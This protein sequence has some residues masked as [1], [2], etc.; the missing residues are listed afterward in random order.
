MLVDEDLVAVLGAEFE[1]NADSEVRRAGGLAHE[2]FDYRRHCRV[3]L[4][5]LL[6]WY[7]KCF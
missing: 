5:A 4:S 1:G 2:V 3:L 7:T 6:S